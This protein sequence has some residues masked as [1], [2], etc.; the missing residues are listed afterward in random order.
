MSHNIPEYQ[1][2]STKNDV[3]RA[4]KQCASRKTATALDFETTA[5]TPQEGK[6]RLASLCNDQD[7][8]LID[9]GV[10]GLEPYAQY[11]DVGQWVVFN[12]GFELR[13]FLHF[14]H[15]PTLLDVGYLRRAILGGGGFSLKLM[16]KWDLDIEMS[17]EQQASNWGAT[18]LSQEQLD[19]AYLDADLT[20]RLWVHWIGQADPDHWRGFALLNGMVPAVVEMETAGMRLDQKAHKALVKD[21]TQ[22]QLQ[23]IEDLRAL[24][25]Q[26]EVDNIN[27][28]AQWSDYFARNMPD[29]FLKGWPR[30][31]KTGQLSMKTVTLNKLAGMVP[32]TPLEKFFDSLAGYKTISK[33]ISS[34]GTTLITSSQNS[35][36][37]R[38]RARFNI[39]QAKTCRFSSS[40]PNLQQIPRDKDLL[41]KATSV[42]R[43]FIAGLGKALVSLDYSGIELRV[44][45]L[46]SNDDQ[47]LQDMVEGDVHSEVATVIAGHKIDKK[48]KE[49][50][51]AR[52]AAKG[53]SFGIIYG[54]GAEGLAA[55]M[56]TTVTKAEEYIAF[57]EDRYRNA[58]NYRFKMLDEAE[59]TRYIRCV[60]GG[61][62]YMGRRPEIPK[63]ANYPVQR[64]ALSIM[65]RAIIRHKESLD[66]H[67]SN[68]LQKRTKMLATIHDALIDESGIKDAKDCLTI[69]EQDMITGYLDIFPGASTD[70]LVEG[71]IGP[72]WAELD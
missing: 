1:L 47:L 52:T 33:Y 70:R 61:T 5:F 66:V 69:M 50:K 26:E 29:N 24:V 65:A 58:F 4:I 28:D 53:V 38:I 9:F 14:G 51:A 59:R 18:D 62:I 43:S 17:K 41:G 16:V 30:T 21:W 36:D 2:V 10:E 32:G 37:K 12:A 67:R 60:D 15:T 8:Y 44:L 6:V 34:F 45:A 55:T 57:W 23:K 39:G 27:S 22:I 35:P 25:P 40:G 71:G 64:A 13:W 48:T 31:E 46:L 63:L 3:I 19:Y 20:W 7:H 54:S 72:N 68:G 42:R 49:G 56:R 11:F